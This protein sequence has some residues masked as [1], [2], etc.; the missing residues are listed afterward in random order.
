VKVRLSQTGLARA[1]VS[2]NDAQDYLRTPQKGW[3]P[4]L[5]LGLGQGGGGDPITALCKPGR[6]CHRSLKPIC[7]HRQ[8]VMVNTG[9]IGWAALADSVRP[10]EPHT[11]PATALRL[12]CA[13]LNSPAGT[14]RAN[15]GAAERLVRRQ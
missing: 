12:H 3:W 5:D 1:L 4:G 6:F 7:Q 13:R 11:S 14:S 9:E 8:V 10:C 15:I 2:L